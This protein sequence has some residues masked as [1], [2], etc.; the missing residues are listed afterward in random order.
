M[1]TIGQFSKLS[2]L[3]GKALRHYEKLGLLKPAIIDSSNQYRYYSRSQLEIAERIVLLKDLGVSL[4]GIKEMIE[5]GL[6]D[7]GFDEQLERHRQKLLSDLDNCNRRL[8]K[9]A[10]WR[11]ERGIYRMTTSETFQIYIHDVPEIMVY[12]RREILSDYPVQ[13]PAMLRSMLSEIEKQGSYTAGPPIIQYYDTEF[14]PARVDL[15]CCWPVADSRLAN[16]T[17]PAIRAAHLVYIG[18]Y[19]AMEKAYEA[20]YSWVNENGYQAVSPMREVSVSDPAVTAPDKLVTE[21]YVPV[22]KA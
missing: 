11:N 21:I 1:Y 22:T 8:L 14:N 13:L 17:L 3:T 20:I 5:H 6:D 16:R 18:P 15:E 2:H 10:W 19:E 12:A 4:T 9:L 7:P